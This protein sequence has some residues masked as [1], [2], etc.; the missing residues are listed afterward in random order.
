ME[1][2]HKY[3][4]AKDKE[5]HKQYLKKQLDGVDVLCVQEDLLFWSDKFLQE[6]GPY[7][8]F[9]RVISSTDQ[10]GVKPSKLKEMVYEHPLTMKKMTKNGMEEKE[11]SSILGNSI[12]LNK[13]SEWFKTNSKVVQISTV[14]DLP[15]DKPLGYRSVVCATLRHEKTDKPVQIL[16]THLSGGRFED[17][18]MTDAMKLE[19]AEQMTMC[20]TAIDDSADNVLVGDF[21][22][23]VTRTKALDGYL[24]M[25]RKDFPDLS[26]AN[27]YSYMMAPFTSMS[28]DKT[29]KWSLL[30]KALDGP[31]SCFNHTVDF[32]MTSP[33][34]YLQRDFNKPPKIDRI[35]MIKDYMPWIKPTADQDFNDEDN[36]DVLKESITDHNGVK[37]TFFQPTKHVI[38]AELTFKA[39]KDAIWARAVENEQW[40]EEVKKLNTS[41]KTAEK[42]N[43]IKDSVYPIIKHTKTE[44]GPEIVKP[45]CIVNLIIVGQKV[46][47]EKFLN[48]PSF[49]KFETFMRDCAAEEKRILTENGWLIEES[50]YSVK[51]VNNSLQFEEKMTAAHKSLHGE[52]LSVLVL[53]ELVK[54][55][56]LTKEPC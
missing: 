23:S 44:D 13:S 26:T 38:K 29:K 18:Y 51:R 30:Y 34:M 8:N 25:L 35:R 36:P 20:F 16:C 11:F 33:Q 56:M 39:V 41:I 2:Y 14:M 55:I 12:Y 48:D 21:N 4:A 49:D 45:G 1:Y 32:F 54:C 22:A 31:T 40:K 28:E 15:N 6:N 53:R 46:A 52:I 7:N 43:M 17:Q 27:Y 9:S 19:R 42:G 10:K 5:S 24:D 50:W 47:W 3:C 37:V